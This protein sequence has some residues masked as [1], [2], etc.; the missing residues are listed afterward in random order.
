MTAVKIH[1]RT[2]GSSDFG[3]D[4]LTFENWL[5]L[6]FNVNGPKSE[7]IN[8]EPREKRAD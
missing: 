4:E 5:W 3:T 7:T 8:K 1:I 6:R 2:D